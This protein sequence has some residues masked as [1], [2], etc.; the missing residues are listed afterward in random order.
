MLRFGQGRHRDA[1]ARFERTLTLDSG[2]TDAYLNLGSTYAAL[3]EYEA[4][5][6]PWGRLRQ[7]QPNNASLIHNIALANARLGRLEEAKADFQRVLALDPS[8]VDAVLEE[9]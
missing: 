7:I 2:F 1:I 5:L 4:A 3:K 6:G 9:P 8:N